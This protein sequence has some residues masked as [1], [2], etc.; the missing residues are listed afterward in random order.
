MTTAFE[1]LPVCSDES[2]VADDD[3]DALVMSVRELGDRVTTNPEV[4]ANFLRQPGP[5]VVFSTY[6]SSP[7]IAKAFELGG[8]APFDLI[9]AD[10]AHRT[11]GP[12]LPT[13]PSPPCSTT[14]KSRLGGGCS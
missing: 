7:E 12:G 3:D 10:E 11:A 5:R 9:V 8:V 1:H 13:R 14:P 2:V 4:I 6:Q